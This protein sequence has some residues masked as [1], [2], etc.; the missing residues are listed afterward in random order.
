VTFSQ[1]LK[2]AAHDVRR[3]AAD[4]T[5]RL[6]SLRLESLADTIEAEARIQRTKEQPGVAP[7]RPWVTRQLRRSA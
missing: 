1:Q 2:A 3:R 6:E 7:A 5:D 4:T